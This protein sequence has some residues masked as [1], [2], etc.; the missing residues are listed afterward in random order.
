MSKIIVSSDTTVAILKED[1]D[2]T[3]V[4]IFPLNVFVDGKEYHDTVDIDQHEL[5]KY[6]RDGS[7]IST[8]TPSPSEIEEY[9]D[10][11]FE[12]EKPDRIIHFTISSKLSS[13]YSL[14]TRV[15]GDRYGDKVV[16][17]DSYS[18]C[19]FM[20]NLVEYTQKL[21]NENIDV[22]TIVQKIEELK[23]TE[24]CIFIPESLEY[25]KRGGRISS[26]VAALAGLIGVIPVLNFEDGAVGKEGVTRTARK[27]IAQACQRWKNI[28]NFEEDYEIIMLNA[29]SKIKTDEIKSIIHEYFPHKKITIYPISINVIAHAGPGT[30]GAGYY[31]KI[32]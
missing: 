17:I 30:I 31:K 29:E 6:M 28:S 22:D 18:I 10:K 19:I 24:Y 1:V 25:L 27:A 11:I 13:M 20:W 4:K 14:F 26:S 5:C 8:S 16:V 9:F 15:C 12:E 7:K 2:K 21:V 3:S 23:G 32:K